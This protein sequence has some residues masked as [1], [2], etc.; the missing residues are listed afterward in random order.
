MNIDDAIK[1]LKD[2]KKAGHKNIIMA[3]WEAECFG[4]NDDDSWASICEYIDDKMD[5]S[6]CHD[7]ISE[8]IG[9]IERN[10]EKEDNHQAEVPE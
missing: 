6:N 7:D 10:F 3:W 4:R 5:W 1:N 2:A 8:T 9:Y